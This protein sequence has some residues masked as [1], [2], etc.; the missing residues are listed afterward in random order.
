MANHIV[1]L[2]SSQGV[3]LSDTDFVPV[4]HGDTL[5]IGTQ[6][7][8]PF[9]L[10]FSPEATAVLTPKPESPFVVP[11][12]TKANFTFESS[13]DGAYTVYYGAL[14]ATAPSMFPTEVSNRLYLATLSSGS[15]S[16]T[17]PGGN[18]SMT[19]GR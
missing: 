19:T 16:F 6:D 12:G 15:G 3:L 1:T 5:T 14:D 4:V 8:S 9:S 7:G 13:Q 2:T 10:Y 17:G 11:H 18:E